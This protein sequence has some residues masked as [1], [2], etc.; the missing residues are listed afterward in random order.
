MRENAPGARPS[1]TDTH[2]ADHQEGEKRLAASG[3]RRLIK[4]DSASLMQM[5]HPAA[6]TLLCASACA[7]VATA[8]LA[9]DPTGT[10]TAGVLSGIGGGFL[11]EIVKKQVDRLRTTRKDD[12]SPEVDLVAGIRQ[13]IDEAI[14]EGNVSIRLEIAEFLARV[15]GAQ[16]AQAT[17]LEDGNAQLADLIT[18]M[19]DTLD[20]EIVE[21]GRSV[22]AVA[23]EVRVN[24]QQFQMVQASLHMILDLL[25]Q[26]RLTWDLREHAKERVRQQGHSHVANP[27]LGL[28]PFTTKDA[29]RFFGRERATARVLLKAADHFNSGMPLMVTGASGSGK[30]SLLHAGFLAAVDG[31]QFAVDGSEHW[32]QIALRPRQPDTDPLMNLATAVSRMAAAPLS[33]VVEQLAR[34]PQTFARY[35]RSLLPSSTDANRTEALV[36]MIDQF[37]EIF[38]DAVSSKHRAK[39]IET[40]CGLASG[41]G[42][43]VASVVI[44]VRGDFVD[45]CSEYGA[46]GGALASPVVLGPLHKDDVRDVVRLPAT[47]AG[48]E[49]PAALVEEILDDA[50]TA[51]D[52]VGYGPGTLP[53]LSEA[54]YRL[55]EAQRARGLDGTLTMSAYLDT[56]RVRHAVSKTAEA[57]YDDLDDEQKSITRSLILYLAQLGSPAVTRNPRSRSSLTSALGQRADTVI[58]AF[59][60]G[61][62]LVVSETAIEVAHE[63]IFVNWERAKRWI[64][65]RQGDLARRSQLTER[66]EEWEQSGR[67]SELLIRGS[68]L[69]EALRD[70]PAQPGVDHG[71]LPPLDA[72]TSAFVGASRRRRTLLRTSLAALA[73]GVLVASLTT[74]TAVRDRSQAERVQASLDLAEAS[75]EVAT[76]DATLARLLAAA[77]WEAAETTEARTAMSNTLTSAASGHHTATTDDGSVLADP[78]SVRFSGDGSAAASIASDGSVAIWDVATWR[79]KK[80]FKQAA[81]LEAIAV[82]SD[83][84]NVAVTNPGSLSIINTTTGDVSDIRSGL[85][86]HSIAFS[87]DDLHVAVSGVP[88]RFRT[89]GMGPNTPVV[90]KVWNVASRELVATARLAMGDGAANPDTY[91]MRKNAS[92]VVSDNGSTVRVDADGSPRSRR[93]GV[94]V[95]Q[96]PDLSD[97]NLVRCDLPCVEVAEA[98]DTVPDSAAR[99][100]VSNYPIDQFSQGGRFGA[101][102]PGAGPLGIQVHDLTNGRIQ[103][104]LKVPS[105]IT[106]YDLSP[107]GTHV[108][109]AVPGGLQTWSLGTD[110]TALRIGALAGHTGQVA[111]PNRTTAVVSTTSDGVQVWDLGSARP[112]LLRTDHRSGRLSEDGTLAVTR[113]DSEMEVWDVQTGTTVSTIDLPGGRIDG[114]G[115]TGNRVVADHREL[116][117]AD[118]KSAY[119]TWDARSGDM[120]SDF[121][122]DYPDGLAAEG[123]FGAAED[124]A[125]T[126]IVAHSRLG[127]L[128][129]FDLES[130]QH[131][132]TL[133]G[134]TGEINDF[135]VGQ[136]G[137]PVYAATE[138]GLY[139]WDS[140]TGDSIARKVMPTLVDSVASS[141]DRRYLFLG[142][143]H[144][145][146]MWD[147]QLE[148]TVTTIPVPS[149]V[150]RLSVNRW[151]DLVVQTSEAVYLLEPPVVST[152]DPLRDVCDRAE[153]D[154]TQE[155]IENYLSQA[156]VDPAKVCDDAP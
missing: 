14:G 79:T 9:I 69:G 63:A 32:R 33:E 64:E 141:R 42:V 135:V 149:A 125:R 146:L 87:P 70:R 81:G 1:T 99:S 5:A 15:D 154:F 155:E 26:D 86:T 110:P 25:R 45:K 137:D 20:Q 35:V 152:K 89:S 19:T 131:R 21:L 22:D 48:V 61:R 16:I 6:I 83:G 62:L 13:G 30:S 29:S 128:Y 3:I 52:T 124:P 58:D 95:F 53:L 12:G 37:E 44:G 147:T 59:V 142:V 118:S 78:A 85:T 97:V 84:R 153:R 100:P 40:V 140:F 103:A 60:Q 111:M 119:T 107:D 105:E 23:T 36:L 43:P 130:G 113:N 150:T 106:S 71:P 93:Y 8:A 4:H 73:V 101:S 31:G 38:D 90:T 54:L 115:F 104:V 77:A 28:A 112:R 108:V 129:A 82:N 109:A 18:H 139:R 50:W 56:G 116:S 10:A 88:E 2:D 132:A 138:S 46:L 11:T 75:V 121:T 133:A 72:T 91:F 98:S 148:E 120:T 51:S 68:R 74:Y 47:N 117:A 145:V 57:I 114:Y 156:P 151:D 49:I 127:A 65:E 55:W 136:R 39:F 92:V 17:A 24:G 27:Y 144:D 94:H 66:A 102:F 80:V 123:V 96:V 67:R 34:P 126:T 41:P 134:T 76:T 143:G 7:P 122:W